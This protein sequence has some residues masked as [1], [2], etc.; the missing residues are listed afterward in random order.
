M[1]K[2]ILLKT[3]KECE[4]PEGFL[5]ARLQG[6]KGGLFR[7]WEFLISTND[8]AAS[9]LDTPFYPY[10]KRYAAPGIWRFLSNEHLWVYAR[11]NAYLRSKFTPYFVYHEISTL[12]VCLRYLYGRREIESVLQQLHNSLLHEEI[13]KI[14]TNNSDFI[15]VLEKLESCLCL[16]SE[17][18]QG[19]HKQFEAKG[20]RAL[21][22]FL[23]N[24]FWSYIFQQVR[25]PMLKTFF[26]DIVDFHNCMALAKNL[27]WEMESEPSY[28]AGGIIST[29]RFKRAYFRKDLTPLLKTMHLQSQEEA[30]SS[31]SDLETAFLHSI[32]IKLKRR[33]SQRSV[34][35]DILFYLWEQFRYCRNISMILNTMSVD[36]DLVRKRIVA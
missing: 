11:M 31:I 22:L 14:L 24:Q 17:L 7:N 30:T 25:E 21:E 6:K 35:G 26:Q 13:Q 23:R 29:D 33:Y 27:R 9:L 34:V 19:L 2:Q 28:I 16:R 8:A 1:K 5:A 18:F 15:E 10:L 12:V 36:D 3:F 20:F 4:Y 32:T